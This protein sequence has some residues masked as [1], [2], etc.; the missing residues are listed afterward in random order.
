MSRE[1]SAADWAAARAD[2]ADLGRRAVEDGRLPDLLMAYQQ[3]GVDRL[4][5][6]VSVLVVEKSR[7]IGYT[8]GLAAY[9]V[10]R[11]AM[12]KPAGGMDVMYISYSQEM[13]REFVDACAM[14]AKAFAK[15][16]AE[17]EEL[18]FDDADPRHPD[19]TR[20]IKAFRI[21]FAS[22]FEIIALSSAPRSLR[23]KQGVVI[24]DE[25]AFVESLAELLKAALA[26]LM[27]G[28]Q[29][30]VVS[31]HNGADNPF[32]GLVHDILEKRKPY[33]LIRVDF[34]EALR[35]GLYERICL[36]KGTPW[37]A[38]GEAGWRQEIIAF[39]GDAGDEELYCVPSEGSGAW[40]PGP[41]ITAR[42]TA[43]GKVL[44]WDLPADFLHR[45]QLVQAGML[46]VFLDELD[47]ELRKL[48]ATERHALGFDFGRVGDLSVVY[49]LAIDQVLAR[50]ARLAVEMRRWPHD[51]QKAVC[52][53][54]LKRLR[55]VGAAFDATGEGNV[56]AEAMQREF[57]AYDL[58]VGAGGLVAAV[59]LSQEWYRTEMP[60]VKAAL[61]DD[62]LALLLDADHRDD[63][64]QIQ[65]IRGIPQVPPLRTGG[66]GKKRHADAAVAIALAEFAA[67]MN[68]ID[69]GY[70][71]APAP[72]SR[73]ETEADDEPSFR[74]ASQRRRAASW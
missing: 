21:G 36:V 72:Q 69:Y 4:L 55:M 41:L 56:I 6:G 25:A 52:R 9:A 68:T 11:A 37:T 71:A 20:Q 66:E 30:V 33:E 46:A 18:L 15:G 34:D 70:T 50:R 32:N 63:L 10:L 31:T 14:W 17:A 5:S 3:R 54:I 1:L 53:A 58:K 61:E 74:M 44:R 65:V 60:P 67:R 64:R 2:A 45:P 13:T 26:F 23:G 62:V 49:L 43:E 38:E 12:E 16:A 42:M 51:E 40:L 39:Y 28:G 29:V 47:G 22:G 24:I 19:E 27:W 35:N 57:G 73:F 7:R 48:D 8:W 59:K